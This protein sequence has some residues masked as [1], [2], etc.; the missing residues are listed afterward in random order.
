MK[1]AVFSTKSFDREFL[2]R[3]NQDFG[4]GLVCFES[5][6]SDVFQR[7]RTFPHVLISGHQGFFTHEALEAIARTTL[8]NIRC[9]TEGGVRDNAIPPPPV[10]K[11]N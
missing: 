3:A 7:L 2:G 10:P 6:L 5:R 8:E 11:S 9:M 4:Y 1:I